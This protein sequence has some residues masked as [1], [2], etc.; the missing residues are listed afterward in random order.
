M[1]KNRVQRKY[2]ILNDTNEVSVGSTHIFRINRTFLNF[3]F[4]MNNKYMLALTRTNFNI[5][6]KVLIDIAVFKFCRSCFV[7]F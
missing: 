5:L 2:L 1:Y 4:T 3:L 7:S 6:C